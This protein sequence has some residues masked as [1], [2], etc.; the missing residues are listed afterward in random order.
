MNAWYNFVKKEYEYIDTPSD[1][2]PY[3][4]QDIA[5]QNLYNLYI[6]YEGLSPID[7]AI[8]VLELNCGIEK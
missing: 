3:I 6:S 5:S 8:K 4:P 7:S 2:S 1:F